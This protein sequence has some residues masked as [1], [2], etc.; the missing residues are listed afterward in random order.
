MKD[1]IKFVDS[2]PLIVKVILAIFLDWLVFSIYRLA[3]GNII[4]AILCILLAPIFWII[5][6]ITLVLDGKITVLV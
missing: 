4:G 2:L 5:D 6:L 1:Y 3:K